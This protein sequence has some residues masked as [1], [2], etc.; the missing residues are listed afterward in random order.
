M[1]IGLLLAYYRRRSQINDWGQ[2]YTY[3]IAV[4]MDIKSG[5]RPA[6][7]G[8]DEELTINCICFSI[9]I[10]KDCICS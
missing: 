6:H 1:T 4:V 2:T 10:F 3:R 7:D 5:Y 8:K 9:F